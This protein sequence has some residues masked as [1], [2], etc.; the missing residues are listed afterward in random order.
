MA[1]GSRR[2]IAASA[3]ASPSSFDSTKL[4]IANRLDADAAWEADVHKCRRLLAFN[5]WDTD[6]QIDR[7]ELVEI[8]QFAFSGAK[9]DHALVVVLRLI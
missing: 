1:S 7:S 9:R 4:H 6:A 3:P 5:V 2:S 8:D